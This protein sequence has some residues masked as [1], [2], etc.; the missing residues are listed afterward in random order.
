MGE[1]QRDRETQKLKQAPGSELS[2]QSP[3]AWLKLSDHEIMTWAEV[4]RLTD[5]ATQVPLQELYL[6]GKKFRIL[7]GQAGVHES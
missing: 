1:G 7:T 6:K 2:A 3:N 4:G 5:W